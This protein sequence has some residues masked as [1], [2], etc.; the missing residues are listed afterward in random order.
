[1]RVFGHPVH[2][3]LVAFPIGLLSLTPICD[4]AAWLG[5]AKGLA[6]VA[7]HLELLGLA[8]GALAGITGFIDFYRLDA[9]ANGAL[10]RTALTHASCALGMLAL[11][12]V[13]FALRGEAAATPAPGVIALEALGAGLITV[14]GWLGGH[15][16]FGFGVG[17]DKT[18]PNERAARTNR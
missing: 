11:F 8:G 7:H 10:S 6:L 3:I 18:P 4:A 2:P 1:V 17:V 15:L 9:P 13:A 5:M 14:T 12:G 16:V